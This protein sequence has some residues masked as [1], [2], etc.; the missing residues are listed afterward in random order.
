MTDKIAD[1]VPSTVFYSEMDSNRRIDI[2]FYGNSNEHREAMFAE[3]TE[4]AQQN[5]LRI[6]FMM[7]YNLF[8]SHRE[9]LI[10]QAK[11][12]EWIFAFALSC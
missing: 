3:F 8:G 4:L 7:N 6:E 9:S 12:A 2:L 1:K 11:V 10:D 5:N